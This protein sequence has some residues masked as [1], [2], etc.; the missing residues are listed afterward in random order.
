MFTLGGGMQIPVTRHWAGDVGYRYS[1]I[2]ADDSL[3]A[4]ALNINGMTFG[5]GY[6]F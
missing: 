1:R 4:S 3:S 5:F 6:R 2:A